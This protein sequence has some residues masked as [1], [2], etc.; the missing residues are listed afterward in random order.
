MYQLLDMQTLVRSAMTAFRAHK[1]IVT[2][3]KLKGMFLYIWRHIQETMADQLNGRDLVEKSAFQV[4]KRGLLRGSKILNDKFIAAWNKDGF[5]DY[6][7]EE[8]SV[9][10]ARHGSVGTVQNDSNNGSRLLKILTAE[11]NNSAERDEDLPPPPPNGAV[12]AEGG[13]RFRINIEDTDFVG[14]E[15]IQPS[16]LRRLLQNRPDLSKLLYSCIEEEGLLDIKS[17]K[18]EQTE[19]EE[20]DEY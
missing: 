14:D 9:S 8:T 15:R 1:S 13:V 17:V 4:G 12:E 6:L 7:Q 2:E 11:D 10:G 3:D 20:F 5:K 18:K 16:Q 19:E